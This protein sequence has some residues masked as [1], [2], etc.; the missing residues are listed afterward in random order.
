M[1]MEMIGFL[2]SVSSCIAL[3]FA[4]ATYFKS[5]SREKTAKTYSEIDDLFEKYAEL[6]SKNMKDNYMD[7]VHFTRKVNRFADLYIAGQ[8]KKSIVKKSAG[9]FLVRIYNEKLSEIISQQRKQFKRE[10]YFSQIEYMIND[11]KK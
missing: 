9:D 4:I 5:V 6:A 8:F 7:F 1:V 11:L 3:I 10:N 2:A